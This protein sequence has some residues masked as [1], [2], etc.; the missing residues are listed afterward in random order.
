VLYTFSEGDGTTVNDV[1]GSD[2][3]LNLTIRNQ[4]AV[5]WIDGALVVHTPTIIDSPELASRL[6]EAI[7]TTHELTIEAWVTPASTEQGGPARIVTLSQDTEHRN[8]ML[9]QGPWLGYPS[10]NTAFYDIRLRTTQTD[11]NGIPSLQSPDDTAEEEELQ[12]VV[13]T[14]SAN[15]EARIYIDGELVGSPIDTAGG[16]LSNW[17][18]SYRLALANEHTL[19]RPWEGTYHLV[20]IYSQALSADEVGQNFQAGEGADD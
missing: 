16:T 6:I 10:G 2:S 17:D 7:M 1:A 11:D 8:F 15:G 13:Y 3:P 12:H 19:D 5:Q 20:A 4:D 14:R 9:G 18:H